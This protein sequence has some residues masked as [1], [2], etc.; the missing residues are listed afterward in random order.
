MFAKIFGQ[1][2]DSSIA[3]SPAL[4]HFFMDLIVL[5][6]ADGDVDMTPES[7]AARTRIPLAEVNEHLACLCSPDKR[8]RTPDK[9]GR[10]LELIDSH[11][12][13]GWHIIN[14]HKFR[15]IA[16]N[17]QRKASQR[18]RFSRWKSKVKESAN[19]PLTPANAANAMQRQ[20]Q[21]Q[22][23]ITPAESGNHQAFIKGWHDNYKA[24]FGLDYQFDGGKDGKAVKELL[25][26]GILVVDL[27]EIAKSAWGRMKWDKYGWACKQSVTIHGFRHAFNQIRVDLKNEHPTSP[28]VNPQPH[29][30][31]NDEL[32][33]QA[34]G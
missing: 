13:W 26:M 6:D 20:K 33:R 12:D 28:P 2:F 23:D 1:I 10:R 22:K 8:S 25:K 29:K 5:A 11:R 32:L 31:T 34:L 15:A 7:I 19:A 4:R 18:E 30:P 14:Y 21:K 24:A 17:E 9:E 16:T 3:C 27:L